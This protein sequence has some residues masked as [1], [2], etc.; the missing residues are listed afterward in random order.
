MTGKKKESGSKRPSLEM[1]EQSLEN[2]KAA[3]GEI[4]AS[5]CSLPDVPES[6]KEDIAQACFDAGVELSE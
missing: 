3:V 6:F 2:L 5:I 1:L 4:A